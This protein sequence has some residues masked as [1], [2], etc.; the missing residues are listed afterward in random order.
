MVKRN[1]TRR[2]A[3]GGIVGAAA[4]PSVAAAELARDRVSDIVEFQRIF[5]DLPLAEAE[6]ATPNGAFFKRVDSSA[7][8]AEVRQRTADG[9]DLLYNER[10][11]AALASPD[12]DTM[13]GSDDGHGGALWSTI[14]GFIGYLRSSVGATVLGF[15]QAG[16]DA[17]TE[18]LQSAVRR[19]GIYPEQFGAVGDG[20][21][22]DLLAITR[23]AAAVAANP[24]CALVFQNR[25]Y[26]ASNTIDL[27]EVPVVRAQNSELVP[28]HDGIAVRYAAPPGQR[29]L[30]PRITGGLKVQWPNYDF[31][32]DR[33]GFYF[34]NVYH[35][36]FEISGSYATRGVWLHANGKGCVYN[37]FI[38]GEMHHHNVGVWLSAETSESWVNSNEFIS[39][40][41]F[42]GDDGFSFAGALYE[43]QAGHI[44][45]DDSVYAPNGN[46]FTDN[47]LEWVGQGFKLARLA[48][49]RNRFSPKRCECFGADTTWIVDTG[50]ENRIDS[51]NVPYIEGYDPNAGPGQRIDVSG[52][53][54]PIVLG[55]AGYK[56]MQ[57]QAQN[58][59]TT[60][61]SGPAVRGTNTGTGPGVV[62]K[63][64]SSGSNP[65]IV[66][67][68]PAGNAAVAIPAAGTWTVHNGTKKVTW[69]ASAA[70]TTGTW[71][72]GDIVYFTNPAAGGHVGAVCV[73]SGNPGSWKNFGSIEA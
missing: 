6:G 9:S 14:A 11:A 18:T 28:L 32:K 60:S 53:T 22:D 51:D 71:T 25:R 26:A 49:T 67:E 70:P 72:R 24:G 69:Q 54:R 30:G 23:A 68:G 63:N 13:I 33:V 66:V 3:L 4:V 42:G 31:T 5:V 50:V 52:A 65:A 64:A 43:P 39:G 8:L 48:G 2:A 40:R 46:W 34:Q 37:R 35:G 20:K 19:Q 12:G 59:E 15:V 36:H 55:M 17:I 57:S 56:K 1:V 47:S 62:A 7:G 61:S 73:A 10:T 16:V 21:T 58:F 29:L 27:S 45:I 38:F 44:Y 41:W